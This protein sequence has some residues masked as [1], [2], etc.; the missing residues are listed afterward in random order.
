MKSRRITITLEV[1]TDAPLKVLRRAKCWDKLGVLFVTGLHT[2]GFPLSHEVTVLQAQ[3]IRP[4]K[5][6]KR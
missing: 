4:L 2:D 1:V 3:A 5:E 6:G